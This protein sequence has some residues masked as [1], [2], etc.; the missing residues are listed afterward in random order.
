[1]HRITYS[2]RQIAPADLPASSPDALL[3]IGILHLA[4][5]LY[6]CVH[7]ERRNPDTLAWEVHGAI[8]PGV[9]VSDGSLRARHAR[10]PAAMAGTVL[11]AQV[12]RASDP[13]V[14]V[15]M[16]VL[17]TLAEV[18]AT[19]ATVVGDVAGAPLLDMSRP[20]AVLEEAQRLLE[21]PGSG[22]ERRAVSMVAVAVGDVVEATGLIPHCWAG[23][24]PH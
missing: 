20:S 9:A 15:A 17:E 7:Q 16:L 4:D 6:S 22:I 12:I 11:R 19:L 5:D 10:L 2:I 23:E 21:V 13:E 18:D 14:N 3:N 8:L 1:M 24:S